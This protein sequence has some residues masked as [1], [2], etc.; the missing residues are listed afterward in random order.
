VLWGSTIGLVWFGV[1][2]EPG[3]EMSA[4][5]H[6]KNVYNGS[7][8]WYGVYLLGASCS[9]PDHDAPPMP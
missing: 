7:A 2:V 4:Q 3:R 6:S 8:A 5:R 9:M 1:M